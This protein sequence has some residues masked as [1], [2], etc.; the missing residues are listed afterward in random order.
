NDF[1]G[2]TTSTPEKRKALF[3]DALNLIIYSKLEKIAKDKANVISKDL[4]KHKI[5]IDSLGDVK[6][7]INKL[8]QQCLLLEEQLDHNNKL[9]IDP[10]N[11]LNVINNNLS[12]LN[13]SYKDLENK[14]N[15][16]L[17]KEKSI[18][19]DKV[20]IENSITE[21]QNKKTIAIKTA[22]NIVDDIK[23][24]KE[25]LKSLSEI[26]LNQIEILNDKINELKQKITYYNIIIQNNI[27]EFEELKIPVPDESICKHCRQYMTDEHKKICKSK[28]IQDMDKCQQNISMAKKEI[29]IFSNEVNILQQKLSA[30]IRCKQQIED[31]NNKILSKNI[32]LQNKKNIHNEYSLLVNKFTED[33]KIKESEYSLLKSELSNSSLLEAKF[34][35]E[36]INVQNQNMVKVQ[37]CIA[38]INKEIAHLNASKA[39]ALYTIDEK[40]K[41]LLKI[42]FLRNKI[43]ELEKKYSIYP[44]VLQAFSSTRIPNLIIQNVLDD[45]QAKANTLLSQLKPG[46]QLSFL[47]EK[48]K[49]DGTEAD[50]L[51]IH[52]NVNGKERYYEQLSGAMK[53]AVTFSLKLGLSFLL[54]EMV[55]TDIKFLLLDEIDQSLDKASVDAF[56]DI[57][58]FFQKDFTILIITHN[59]R[60]KDKFSHAIL[61]EQD[62]NM[63]SR[64]KVVSN[65]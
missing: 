43:Q 2:L 49:G 64:A 28:I 65:W 50:T 46:L 58:K 47:I 15:I 6:T 24:S 13:S 60:L 48:V 44:Q 22:K 27:V 62:V 38:S 7:D 33:L 1:S 16:L 55:G 39:V 35:Q 51:D 57:V 19:S 11:Q 61:V 36:S 30:L 3:K 4:E 45:L 41:D 42:D 21:Y 12:N 52:Y 18:L 31:I 17:E 10:T 26:D 25:T 59:D 20:R 29:S 53:L 23:N 37:S 9:L 40:T 32:D 5:L 56:A 14:Y 8:Q 34:I 63:I 54:Q